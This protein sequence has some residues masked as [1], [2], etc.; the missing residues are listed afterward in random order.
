LTH[1][2]GDAEA[3]VPWAAAAFVL[4]LSVF[5][6]TVAV[7]VPLN[8][9]LKAAGEPSQIGNVSAVRSAFHETRW[10]IWNVVRAVFT[11]AAFGCLLWALVLHGR[12]TA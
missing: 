8:D 1:R 5:V 10:A 9:A 2:S 4:Y 12:G 6:I 11:T 7:N 3:V